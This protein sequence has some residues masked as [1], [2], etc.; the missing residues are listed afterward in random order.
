M[1][2]AMKIDLTLRESHNRSP[3]QQKQPSMKT[4]WTF[5]F[6][7]KKVINRKLN[8]ESSFKW[9]CVKTVTE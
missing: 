1:N 3:H 2:S 6:S 8:A 9:L 4:S 5:G 7:N